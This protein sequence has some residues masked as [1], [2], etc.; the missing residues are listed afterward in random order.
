M[1]AVDFYKLPRAI[2]DRF[3]G[4]VMSG[5]PPAALLATKG[6]MPTKRL[7]LGVT[8]GCF[9]VLVVV[10]R[11]GYGSLESGLAI[12]S[13]KALLLY[14]A[15]AFGFVFGLLQAFAFRV[16]ERA[17]PYAPGIYLFPACLI[18]ARR[19]QFKV[20][21]T[22]DIQSVDAVGG[23]VR[24]A[25][26]GGS[27]FLF[28]GSS[29]DRANVS[30]QVALVQASRDR[31]MHAKASD[32]PKEL[33]A[34][35]PLHNPRFSSPVG[36][37]EAYTMRLPPWKK[38]GSLVALAVGSVVA[39]T[40]WAVRNRHSDKTLYARATQANDSP[41]Y[42]AYLERGSTFRSDVRDTL[43]P[44]AELR[45]AERVG[46]VD[47]LLAYSASH[48]AS[49]IAGE[50]SVSIRTMMLA[51][52]EKAKSVGSLAALVDFAKRYPNHGVEPELKQ[53][54]H[55]VYVRELDSFKR[56]APS[57]DK[58][59]VSFVERLFAWA[60]LHG[61]AF[62]VRFRRKKS[63]SIG[64]ADQMIAK[65]PSFMG[66]VSYPSRY[67]DEKHA[68]KREA[69]LGKTFVARFDSGLGPE[70]FDFS[71]GAQVPFDAETLPD[72]KVP[73]LFVTHTAEWSGHSYASQKPRGSYI[74]IVFPIDAVFVLP[75]EAKPLKLRADIT[76][77]PSLGK[78]KEQD[79]SPGPA[80][81][82]TYDAMATE[83]FDAFATRV[84][85]HF[86]PSVVKDP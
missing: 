70:L 26:S 79:L 48:P 25:F 13:W 71:L 35:D 45:D 8:G 62:D 54:I 64:R 1:K 18:D 3:V 50:I 21:A 68:T 69:A 7:W 2:Q 57:K 22:Q 32:D 73:T 11:L 53:S 82:W 81:D 46:T 55:A 42:R 56:A 52:L 29:T 17:L 61:G 76:K 5:F 36:P 4:S 72:V 78:L 33:V 15:L 27:E 51:E 40:V 86:F 63:E 34:V 16:R 20:Y 41:S 80:E 30:A 44:R 38:L 28:V 31:A 47:A 85:A 75:G 77:H 60:E 83:A 74:G 9:V 23:A 67:F 65:T 39:V 10:T 19:E 14:A 49:K 24:V 66:E 6:A 12:H 84:L 43:L 37:R 59:I 58:N